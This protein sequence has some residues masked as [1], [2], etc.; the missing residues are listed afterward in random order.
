M[1]LKLIVLIGLAV[2]LYYLGHP[3]L[4]ALA[5]VSLVPKAGLIIAAILAIILF[6]MALYIEGAILAAL[7]VFNLVGNHFIGKYLGKPNSS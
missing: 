7:I 3:S 1:I 5:I 6:I 4:A 2:R